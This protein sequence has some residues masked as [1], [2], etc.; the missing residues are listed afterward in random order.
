MKM[1]KNE[2]LDKY[3]YD[4]SEPELEVDRMVTLSTCHIKESTAEM[5]NDYKDITV[6]EKSEYGW[7]MYL[8]QSALGE[9]ELSKEIPDDLAAVI[10]F[11]K[12]NNFTIL[13]LDRDGGTVNRLP[14][15]LW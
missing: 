12:D 8:N 6:Y 3:T 11:A 5:M 14:V 4:E 13:C 1:K 15:Y 7:F 9:D 2:L 10:R